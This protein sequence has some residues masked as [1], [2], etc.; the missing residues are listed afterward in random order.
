MGIGCLA[1][2]FLTHLKEKLKI[3]RALGALI[4][5]FLLFSLVAGLFFIAGKLVADQFHTFE[6]QIPYLIQRIEALWFGL[7]NRY[8]ELTPGLS[9]FSVAENLKMGALRLIKGL[10]DG[11]NAAAGIVL[12]FFIA[13]YTAIHTHSY[14]EGW[15]QLFPRSQQKRARQLSI[16]SAQVLRQWFSAQLLDMAIVG[17]LTGMGLWLVGVN[18]W[19]VFGVMTGVLAIIPYFGVLITLLFVTLITLASQ[20]DLVLWVLLVFFITQQIEGNIL[21]PMIMKERVKL[22]EAPLLFAIVLMSFWFGV[23]GLIIAPG[24]YAIGR[25]LYLNLT[26]SG[27]EKS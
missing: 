26:S 6:E 5:I 8:P 21:L 13:L 12:A 15:I 25:I 17:G 19:A 24:L 20:P 18:Y 2:P 7:I 11:V 1:S 14:F 4:L 10:G 22:P 16:Q 27:A 9:D 23:L 3:P